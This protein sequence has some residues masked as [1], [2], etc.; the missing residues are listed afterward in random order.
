MKRKSPRRG[1]V[2]VVLGVAV[3][4]VPAVGTT[5]TTVSA[6]VS[7]NQ[8]SPL[9]SWLETLNAYRQSSG[10]PS[11]ANDASLQAGVDL[12]ARYLTA[13]GSASHTED[14]ANPRY[15]PS[16][17]LAASQ[18]VLGAWGGK[19]RNDREVIEDWL[20][21]PFHGIHLL[22]PRLLRSAF[23]VQRDQLGSPFESAGVLNVTAG[24]GP[25]VTFDAP[26]VFPGRD[27]TVPLTRFLTETPSPLTHCPGYEA[28][29]GLPLLVQFPSAPEDT[30]ADVRSNGDIVES[31]VIDSSYRNP[32]MSVQAVGR[33]L[34]TQKNAVIVL[35]HEP[36][37]PGNTYEVTVRGR[38]GRIHYLEIHGQ[39]ARVSTSRSCFTIRC[40]PIRI[41]QEGH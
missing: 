20:G 18:S 12:H 4:L 16:G 17:A 35:P 22:E 5:A 28:P 25:K 33:S 23:G 6:G 11:V 3:G 24:I 29:A 1:R 39:P 32:S 27:A 30:T 10:L 7:A 14:P 9:P 36:L 8:G 21:A 15:S 41:P 40:T 26:I 37:V 31:C 2:A 19:Q 34:L 13:T 38:P